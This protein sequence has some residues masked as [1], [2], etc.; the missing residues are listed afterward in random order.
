MEISLKSERYTGLDTLKA[1]CAFLVVCIHAP[2]STAAG[3]YF[4]DICRLAVPVFFM[5]S[6]FFYPNTMRRGR[7]AKQILRL[8][9]L[10]LISM[11]CYFVWM[12]VF[13]RWTGQDFSYITDRLL[14]FK[15]IVK[16]FVFNNVNFAYHLWYL[17][18]I[19]YVLVMVKI[20]V[21]LRLKKLLFR[22]CP[23][24]L[25]AGIALG[26]YSAVVFGRFISIDIARN[27]YFLGLPFFCAG[28]YISENFERI[29]NRANKAALLP[30]ALAFG[31][32][33]MLEHYILDRLGL[34]MV[35]DVY[36]ST[37]PMVVCVFLFF[38]AF[39]QGSA[40]L[41]TIGRRYSTGIYILHVA[42]LDILYT[43]V[44][45]TAFV[46]V[47]NSAPALFVYPVTLFAVCLWHRLSHREVK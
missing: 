42:V 36:L 44:S 45:K 17:L 47:F 25:L 20:A 41:S 18:A 13:Y 24:L 19:I 39:S 46:S 40:G 22:L 2:F 4:E 27:C 16:L 43:I 29:K 3:R 9:K 15:G 14:S 38:A 6:G 11:L 35:G 12:Y 30:L 1:I 8:L 32:L 10:T 34:N 23:L 21:R 26:K 5:A 28:W 7:E 31:I 37:A 33:S